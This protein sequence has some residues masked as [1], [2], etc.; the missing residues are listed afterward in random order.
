MLFMLFIKNNFKSWVKMKY[1]L[2]GDTNTN[3]FVFQ[4]LNLRRVKLF[5]N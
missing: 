5:S 4:P 1:K 2:N 3:V